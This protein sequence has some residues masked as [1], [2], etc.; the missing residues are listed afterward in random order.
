MKG[1]VVTGL[2][3][4]VLLLAAGVFAFYA[5]RTPALWPRAAWVFAVVV[6]FFLAVQVLWEIAARDDDA[7]SM[8]PGGSG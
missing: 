1:K 5:A 8:P 2:L 6:P 7:A 3:V 4:A